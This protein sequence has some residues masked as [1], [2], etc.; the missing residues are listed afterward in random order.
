MPSPYGGMPDSTGVFS[1]EQKSL[2]GL[3]EYFT[4][5]SISQEVPRMTQ[6][7]RERLRLKAEVFKSMGHPIRLGI[8]EMLAQ[9]ERCVCEIFEYVG[10]DI[11][12]VSKHLALLRQNGLVSDRK[13]GLKVFYRLSM[14]CAVDFSRCVENVVLRR[15]DG[16]RAL[17]AG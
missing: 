6:D 16:Q 2:T 8:I 15:L 4:I 17:L 10:T 13:A 9:G 1:A 14:P 7:E 3:Q 5:L 11:S 12:N